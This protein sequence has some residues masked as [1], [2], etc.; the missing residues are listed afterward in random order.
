MAE[1]K[2]DR[3][4][5]RRSQLIN[6]DYTLPQPSPHQCHFHDFYSVSICIKG[7]MTEFYGKGFIPNLCVDVDPNNSG[8][9][10]SN[11]SKWTL[12]SCPVKIAFHFD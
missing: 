2:N 4:K 7:K 3:N 5:E 10:P 11:P 1:L 12:K 9:L 6:Q 8:A